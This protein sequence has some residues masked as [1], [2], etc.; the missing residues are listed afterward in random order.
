MSHIFSVESDAEKRQFLLE[1]HKMKHL[2]EDV[3][4]FQD[5]H[6][7]CFVC[8][9]DHLIDQNTC[10][11]DLLEAGPSCRDLSRLNHQH[12]KDRAGCYADQNVEGSSAQ[13]YHLGFRKA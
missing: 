6:S 13:T 2:F 7:W 8:Q 11:I 5:G 12:R 10:G 9:C 1:E 4:I 3:R